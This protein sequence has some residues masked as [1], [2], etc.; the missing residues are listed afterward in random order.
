M[1]L[2]FRA[3]RWR[4]ILLVV[5]AFPAPAL[6]ADRTSTPHDCD[7]PTLYMPVCSVAHDWTLAEA[8]AA[9]G[10]RDTAAVGQGDT[11]SILARRASGPVTLC[12]TIDAP[13]TRIGDSDIW[14]LSVRVQSLDRAIIDLQISPS[15]KQLT[16]YYGVHVGKPALSPRLLG[17]LVEETLHSEAL[18]EARKLTIYVPPGHVASERIPVV[19]LADGAML[20]GYAPAIE[21]E[22]VSG[23][24]RPV[25]VVG[26]WPGM[27]DPGMRAREYL[28]GRSIPRFRNQRAFVIDEVMPFVERSYGASGK[29]DERMLAGFSDGAAW[30][31]SMGLENPDLFGHVAALSLGW[32][33]AAD[34]IASDDRPRVFL[35]AGFLEPDFYHVTAQAAHRAQASSVLVRFEEFASGHVPVAWQ[36]MLADALAWSFPR[37]T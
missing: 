31:L 17:R 29:R 21:A 11:L 35:A 32:P 3:M 12:C 20:E 8:A 27:A 13:L 2:S 26:I 24:I 37:G 18:G 5:L 10:G 33:P 23:R 22:I 4:L 30:A 36:T 1:P 34:E 25:L 14:A 15:G 19:Y 6:S 16:A 7:A 9:L 28:I